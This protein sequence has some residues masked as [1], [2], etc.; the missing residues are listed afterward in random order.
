MGAEEIRA[1][2]THLA[3]NCRVAASTQNVALNALLFLY[4]H[5]LKQ[6]FPSLDN[7]EHA[8]RPRR[9]PAVFT[10]EEVTAVLV[11]S[12]LYAG[13]PS[14]VDRTRRT[15]YKDAYIATLHLSPVSMP[16]T[17]ARMLC[18]RG[19]GLGDGA[20]KEDKT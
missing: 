2:L 3:I 1:C 19:G 7:L 8:K 14:A 18:H 6:E 5:V 16:G 11:V 15:R 10:R 9:V 12:S 4:R 17:A 13:M 20:G